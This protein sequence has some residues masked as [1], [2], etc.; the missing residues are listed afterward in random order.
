MKRPRSGPAHGS[1]SAALK[2]TAWHLWP[3]RTASRSPPTSGSAGQHSPIPPGSAA[4]TPR[5]SPPSTASAATSSPGQPQPRFT[6]T[7][8]QDS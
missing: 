4:A 6:L 8:Q 2:D 7:P 5:I 3:S 1:T